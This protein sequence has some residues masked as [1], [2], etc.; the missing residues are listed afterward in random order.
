M[1][2]ESVV[3]PIRPGSEEDFEAAFARAEPL[4]VCQA[5]YVAH[6][7]RRG[8]EQPSTYLLSVEWE[9]VEAHEVGFRGSADYQE[10][11][12]LLHHFYITLP[13]VFHYAPRS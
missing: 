8:V 12:R 6:S 2:L 13:Q 5:G 3:L 11:K 1:I 7:L 9:T 10:W 4:I